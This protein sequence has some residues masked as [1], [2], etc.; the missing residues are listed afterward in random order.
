MNR[1]T[2]KRLNGDA[3]RLL[4]ESQPDLYPMGD[5]WCYEVCSESDFT[6]SFRCATPSAQTEVCRMTIGYPGNPYSIC[7]SI[8]CQCPVCTPRLW[9]KH[10]PQMPYREGQR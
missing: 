6:P 4:R 7:V 1:G 8:A 5:A 2:I 3:T 10:L 9:Y